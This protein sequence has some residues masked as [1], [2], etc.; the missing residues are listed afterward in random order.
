MGNVQVPKY[1]QG[2]THRLALADRCF[3]LGNYFCSRLSDYEPTDCRLI[4]SWVVGRPMRF[5]N[6]NGVEACYSVYCIN[7]ERNR[8]RRLHSGQACRPSGRCCT[9]CRRNWTEEKFNP[10][11]ISSYHIMVYKPHYIIY[12]T[13]ARYVL[14]VNPITCSILQSISYICGDVQSDRDVS[15]CVWAGWRERER[16]VEY[17]IDC[18][19]RTTLL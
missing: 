3:L 13:G 4:D 5:V 9:A 10:L 15:E 14:E 16:V 17:S 6:N 7:I 8:A 18:Q 2:A 12:T 1:A 11:T 19:S